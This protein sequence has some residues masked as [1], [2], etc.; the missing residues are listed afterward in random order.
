M[1][2]FGILIISL[3]VSFWLIRAW[4]RAP[5]GTYGQDDHTAQDRATALH[6]AI[7]EYDRRLSDLKADEKDGTITKEDAELARA[8]IARQ[9]LRQRKQLEERGSYSNITKDKKAEHQP[10][11]IIRFA[12]A[13]LIILLPMIA[14]GLYTQIG[15][16]GMADYPLASRSAIIQTPTALTGL[17]GN[18]DPDDVNA[19]TLA[20]TET[21]IAQLKE[22]L[23]S[24][25]DDAFSWQIL[26][27]IYENTGRW[28]DAAQAWDGLLASTPDNATALWFAGIHAA[29][30]EKFE[31][32]RNHWKKL[33]AQIPP[34]TDA[35]AAI[36]ESINQ[37]EQVEAVS[38]KK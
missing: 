4:L 3:L 9:L 21:L 23:K 22:R 37:L 8:E 14:F 18:E 38:S 12:G 31:D 30:M 32:A 27:R 6:A 15:N 34:D 35:Y 25:P 19:E 33:Q 24:T 28:D 7:A 17:V 11:R 29:R 36:V 26:A 10:E 16:P 2:E 13:A 5:L 20:Q 1:F